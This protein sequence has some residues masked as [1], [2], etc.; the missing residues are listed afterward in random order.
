M[1]CKITILSFLILTNIGNILGQKS[2][3]ITIPGDSIRDEATSDEL[4]HFQNRSRNAENLF[5]TNQFSQSTKAFEGLILDIKNSEY[6]K[7]TNSERITYLHYML[8]NSLLCDFIFGD[9]KDTTILKQSTHYLETALKEHTQLTSALLE[10]THI[11]ISYGVANILLNNTDSAFQY[12]NLAFNSLR[13]QVSKFK[14]DP[15]NEFEHKQ[16]LLIPKIQNNAFFLMS[17]IVKKTYFSREITKELYL[18]NISQMSKI[19]ANNLGYYDSYSKLFYLHSTIICDQVLADIN[20]KE[21]SSDLARSYINIGNYFK[22]DFN[23]SKTAS[24]HYNKAIS[25]FNNDLNLSLSKSDWFEYCK[26]LF[27]MANFADDQS[28]PKTSLVYREKSLEALKNSIDETENS[29]TIHADNFGLIYYKLAQ[30]NNI[31]Q[32]YNESIRL[33]ELSTDFYRENQ[34]D[35]QYDIAFNYFLNADN[36]FS[37]KKNQEAFSNLNTSLAITDSDSDS[38]SI[39]N[40]YLR[41]QVFYKMAIIHNSQNEP[42]KAINCYR[43]SYVIRDSI[44]RSYKDTADLDKMHKMVNLMERC[45]VGIRDVNNQTQ[46]NLKISAQSDIIDF[47]KNILN[48]EFCAESYFPEQEKNYQLYYNKL[49]QAYGSLSWYYLLNG[50]SKDARSAA[51]RALEIN[52]EETWIKTNLAGSYLLEGNIKPA[53][54][55]YKEFASLKYPDKDF[56]YA[57]VCI[58]DINEFKNRGLLSAKILRKIKPIEKYLKSNNKQL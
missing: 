41:A 20:K 35:N 29:K 22:E 47:Y 26:V 19:I 40:S 48:S 28:D 17:S 34:K 33:L 31:L 8:G 58:D 27:T 38:D 5:Y 23:D 57:K 39:N 52:N 45:L 4:T 56:T 30:T 49:A 36:Y 16:T 12:F 7:N 13:A 18:L 21:Y 6:L 10:R 32:N 50:Q 25:V 11:Y 14:N 42:E 3:N 24:V 37:L 1:K 44:F 9:I 43:T 54:D 46:P 55:T 15:F 53:L 51:L 2:L